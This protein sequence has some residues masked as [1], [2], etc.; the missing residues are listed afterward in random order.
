MVDSLVAQ[1]DLLR[2]NSYSPAPHNHLS[3]PGTPNGTSTP[4][5]QHIIP[6]QDEGYT[7]FTFSGKKAQAEQVSFINTLDA[8][9]SLTTSDIGGEGR[10]GQGLLA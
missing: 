4:K 10:Q 9:S 3:V 1:P 7:K 6:G 5:S 2:P 8:L